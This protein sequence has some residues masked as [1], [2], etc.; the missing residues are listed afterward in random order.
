MAP[1]LAWTN[2]STWIFATT[3]ANGQF[4]SSAVGLAF[5]SIIAKERCAKIVVVV[6]FALTTAN[7]HFAAVAVKFA[8]TAANGRVAR[9]AVAVKF[10][11][12]I[13]AGTAVQFA[14]VKPRDEM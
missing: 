12:T 1:T 4:A 8:L 14:R 5:A 13:A 6:G 2:L 3:T 9:S 11:L 10:A 7:G